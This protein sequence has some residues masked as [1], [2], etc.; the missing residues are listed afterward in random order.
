MADNNPNGETG[1]S[2]PKVD[3]NGVEVQPR[4]ETDNNDDN[5]VN[6]NNDN[7]DECNNDPDHGSTVAHKDGDEEENKDCMGSGDEGEHCEDMEHNE[8]DKGHGAKKGCKN[9]KKG[10]KSCSKKQRKKSFDLNGIHH[11]KHCEYNALKDQHLQSMFV[12]PRIRSHLKKQ[13]LVN[14]RFLKT[15]RSQKKV[16]LS[17]ILRSIVEIRIY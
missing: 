5:A 8:E 6:N 13:N 7:H 4:N 12:C 2:E 10:K 15:K 3:E 16:L 17:K 9:K 11:L 14:F 1:D